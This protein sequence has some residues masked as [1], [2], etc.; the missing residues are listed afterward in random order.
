MNLSTINALTKYLSVP[1]IRSVSTVSVREVWEEAEEIDEGR[2][3]TDA[4]VDD[5]VLRGASKMTERG[6]KRGFVVV[7]F[8]E[9]DFEDAEGFDVSEVGESAY[10]QV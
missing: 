3:M 9:V 7:E 10:W 1:A 2:E 6:L 5:E 8:V 4:T